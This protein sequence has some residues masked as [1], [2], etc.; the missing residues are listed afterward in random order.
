MLQN[1]LCTT[2]VEAGLTRMTRGFICCAV[3]LMVGQN[4]F[5][6]VLKSDLWWKMS[7][8]LNNCVKHGVPHCRSEVGNELMAQFS[9]EPSKS[10]VFNMT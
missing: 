9:N 7:G 3:A 10:L 5:L 4:M 6:P 8:H 1:S 2:T